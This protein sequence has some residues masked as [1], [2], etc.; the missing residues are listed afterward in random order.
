MQP[1]RSFISFYGELHSFYSTIISIFIARP[2]KIKL[3]CGQAI[4]V[5]EE[6]FSTY[7]AQEGTKGDDL[8]KQHS[9]QEEV[10]EY[11]LL[12]T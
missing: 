1:P 2:H 12:P 3:I 6:T 7:H 9:I 10:K 4:E 5:D 11:L 8:K